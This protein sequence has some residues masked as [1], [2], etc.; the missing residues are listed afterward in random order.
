MQQRAVRKLVPRLVMV[1]DD[2]L[3]SQRSGQRHLLD[4]RDPAIDGDQH[5]RSAL[6]QPLD[7]GRAEPVA[8]GDPVR[9]Q[10]VAIG[11]P[12]LA[13][14]ADHDRCRTDAVDVEVAVDRDPPLGADR[15]QNPLDNRAHRAKGIGR[16][17][18]VGVEKGTS[19]LRRAIA[20][21]HQRNRH[22]IAHV[23]GLDQR[24]SLAVGERV[25]AVRVDGLRHTPRLGSAA[26]ESARFGGRK[27]RRARP[28]AAALAERPPP[29]P[30]RGRSRRPGSRSRRC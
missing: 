27:L 8:V 20:A 3:Y 11:A 30:R 7:I 17:R 29:R 26:A 25:G 9:D 18:L 21:P 2:D 24:P 28:G 19:L 6:G 23:Q 15:L 16:V 1:G 22:R 13:Q 5:L 14:R 12:K 10:P 4:G